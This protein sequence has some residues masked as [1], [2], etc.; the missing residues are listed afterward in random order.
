MTGRVVI[1][2]TTEMAELTHFYL[3]HD[4]AYQVAAFTVD[5][6]Y[7]KE[8]TKWGLPVVPFEDLAATYPPDEYAMFVA[9]LFGRVNKSRAEK[10]AEAKA[11]GYRLISYVS[12]K[13]AT[14]PGVA[15]GDNCMILGKRRGATAGLYRQ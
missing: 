8:E 14:W 6:A 2:G 1:F 15:I 13:A 4:S 7:I 11:K 12:S 9:L 5:R 10:Y 3:T